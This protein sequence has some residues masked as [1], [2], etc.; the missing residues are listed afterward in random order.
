M[1]VIFQQIASVGL[2]LLVLLSTVS[3][4]VEKHMCMGRTMDIALFTG[5]EGCG[6]DDAL[7]VMGD[8]AMDN[9]CCD[10]ESFTLEGQ[11]NLKLSITDLDLEQQ[12]FLVAFNQSYLDLF[13][14]VEEL[15]IP[16]EKYPPPLLVKDIHILD[17]VFLI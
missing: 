12:V 7:S 13:V 17:Q 8:E 9:Q 3:W 16:H 10:D 11:D 1:K 2:S 5:A 15:P 14:P 6:L 4:T